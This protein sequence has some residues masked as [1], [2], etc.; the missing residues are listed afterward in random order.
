MAGGLSRPSTRFSF[1]RGPLVTPGIS[2]IFKWLNGRPV[3]AGAGLQHHGVDGRDEPG[4]DGRMDPLNI[5]GLPANAL[6]LVTP[7]RSSLCPRGIPSSL[8]RFRPLFEAHEAEALQLAVTTVTI[9]E[10]M[11]GPEQAKVIALDYDIACR[12]GGVAGHVALEAARGCAG[13]ECARH[14]RGRP[15]DARPEFLSSQIAAYADADHVLSVTQRSLLTALNRHCEE[16]S[17]STRQ[18]C[19]ASLLVPFSSHRVTK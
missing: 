17:G 3:K 15:G 14:R 4:D 7:R 8:G 12:A 16:R 6:V 19:P 5:E 13:C 9:A 18:N 1:S 11:T 2:G 10:V